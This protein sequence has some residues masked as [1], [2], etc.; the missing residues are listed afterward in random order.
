MRIIRNLILVGLAALLAACGPMYQTTYS[1]KPPKNFQGRQ[2]VNRCLNARNRCNFRCERLNQDCRQQALNAARPQYRAYR[3]RQR[4]S[5][6][7]V[8]MSLNDFA[9]FSACQ[10]NCGC[11]PNYRQ[12]Y[13][14][15]GGQVIP[16]TRCVAFC[17]K[18]GAKSGAPAASP[19]PAA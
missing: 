11:Q 4:W 9:D 15:C 13:S 14:N 17:P 19:A 10:A 5:G 1:F 12:C 2:C 7:P 6:K 8:T 18:P 16:F 3:R